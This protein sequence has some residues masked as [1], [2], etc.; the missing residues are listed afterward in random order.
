[1]T[2]VALAGAALFLFGAFRAR[3]F[4]HIHIF[5]LFHSKQQH[6]H[7]YKPVSTREQ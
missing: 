7:E 5:K 3:E 6:S 2:F 1:M 4:N